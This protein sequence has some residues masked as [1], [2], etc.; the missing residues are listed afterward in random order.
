MLCSTQAIYLCIFFAN[1]HLAYRHLHPCGGYT[2]PWH[3]HLAKK[4]LISSLFILLDLCRAWDN[5]LLLLY[6]T[7]S[8]GRLDNM[9]GQENLQ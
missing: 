1:G 3:L 2:Y 9:S 4:Q 5:I 8:E 7:V 6:H